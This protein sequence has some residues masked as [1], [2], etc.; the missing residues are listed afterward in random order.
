MPE[1]KLGLFIRPCGHHIASWRHPHC[2]SD[3][4]V[5]FERFVTMAKT[6]ER[7]LFDML[8]SADTNSA[9]TTIEVALNRQHYTAWLE[10]FTLLSTLAAHTSHIG[11]VCTQSTSFD[12]PYNIARRFA[13]LDLISGGRAGWNVVTTGNELAALNYNQEAHL[14]KAERYKIAREFV[15]VVKGLWDSWD[16]D[17]FVRDR[18]NSLFFPREKMHVLDHKW[19]YFQVKGPLNVA[20]SPQGQPVVV[21]AGASN[22]GIELA[23][24]TADVVFGASQDIDGARKFYSELKG[25][26]ARYGR[27][28]DDLKILPGLSVTVAPTVEEAQAK[29][30]E[31]QNLIHPDVGL[32]LLSRRIGYDLTGYDP[33][34]PV[35]QMPANEDVGSR[36]NQMF[37]LAH[38]NKMTLRQLY[39][40][41]SAARGHMMLIGTPTTVVD[42]MQEWFENGACDGFNILPPMFPDDLE[43][44]VDL[45]VPELQRRGLFRKSY[46]GTTLR[47]RLG[48]KAPES[49]YAKQRPQAAE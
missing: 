47:D 5:N 23:A 2:H 20:R 26:L 16:D 11:L 41:F 29:H 33:D 35:P 42:A 40:H 37:E 4:G 44:F 18:E 45:V 48:L 39:Q 25:R 30:Q 19:A 24:A 36:S 14:P 38:R 31:L 1:M 43:S 15:D 10:P 7:G 21:Q 8:F 28:P 12:Q 32:A 34:A 13:A 9:W 27:Q 17:A 6:A 22:D 3:A 46:E 49:R